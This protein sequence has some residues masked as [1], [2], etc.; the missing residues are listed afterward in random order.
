M[1]SYMD[2]NIIGEDDI[3]TY[4]ASLLV[5]NVQEMVR[6]N[7]LEV[8][9]RYIRTQEDVAKINCILSPE[10]PT[11]DLSSLLGGCRDELEK[12][13]EACQDWG[14]FQVVNHGMP[15][16]VMR[17]MNEVTAQFFD[18]PLEEKN[19]LSMPSDDIQG[20]G[21]AYVVSEDQKLDWSDALILIIYPNHFRRLKYWP[22]SPEHF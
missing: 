13:H 7:P 14:F 12:L 10:I 3:P 20:Y 22:T 21:H 6:K 8:P 15:R 4:A 18:L 17:A 9:Q 19:K 1:G 2:E 11:I 5:P 16:Q